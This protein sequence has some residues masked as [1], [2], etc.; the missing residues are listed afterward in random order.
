V[1]VGHAS[2]ATTGR[3]VALRELSERLALLG[4][5]VHPKIQ[6]RGIV[7]LRLAVELTI[8]R[9]LHQ[10]FL[11]ASDASVFVF[12]DPVRPHVYGLSTGL[13]TSPESGGVEVYGDVAFFD[14]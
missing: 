5:D 10:E 12:G 14:R 2:Q 11:D 1:S 9:V 6:F 13:V 7:V 3:A 4:Q 8:D